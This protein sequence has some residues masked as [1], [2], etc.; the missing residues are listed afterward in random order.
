[1][2]LIY[3]PLCTKVNHTEWL[4]I[5]LDVSLNNKRNPFVIQ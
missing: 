3:R 1:M 2:R 5:V 4:I